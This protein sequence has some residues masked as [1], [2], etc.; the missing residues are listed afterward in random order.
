MLH[1]NHTLGTQEI[2][3]HIEPGLVDASK[4]WLSYATAAGA[5]L[6]TV[7]LAWENMAERGAMSVLCRTAMTTAR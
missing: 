6:F 7:K 2:I 5:G 4:L 1:A 3:M